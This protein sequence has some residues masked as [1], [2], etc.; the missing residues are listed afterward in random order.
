MPQMIN[1]GVRPGAT[2][3]PYGQPSTPFVQ[4]GQPIPQA[5]V[6]NTGPHVHA[7]QQEDEQIYHSGSVAGNDGVEDLREK[8][9]E[10]WQ[11]MK[12]L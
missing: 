1:D 11:E 7:T 12:A 2:E 9:D 4:P 5:V 3:M 6:T 8:Y 10:M